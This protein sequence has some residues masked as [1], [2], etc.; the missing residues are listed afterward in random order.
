MGSYSVLIISVIQCGVIFRLKTAL[1]SGGLYSEPNN[2][3]E[4]VCG[5]Y[6]AFKKK[7]WGLYSDLKSSM[8]LYSDLKSSMGLYSELDNQ[9]RMVCGGIFWL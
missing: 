2:H 8:G 9:C 7:V 4:M 5:V 6:Y 1:C 3:Y